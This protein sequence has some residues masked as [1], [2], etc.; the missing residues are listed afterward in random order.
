MTNEQ[1]RFLIVDQGIVGGVINF[2]VNGA[3]AWYLF[4]AMAQVPM[5]GGSQ[6]I[7][8]DVVGTF[9]LLPLIVCL[10]VTPLVRRQVRSGKLAALNWDRAT[11]WLYR[12]MPAS[13]FMRGLVLGVA[14]TIV[15]GLPLFGLM[16]AF[17]ITSMAYWDFVITKG[18]YAGVLA[19]IISPVIAFAALGDQLEVAP[20]SA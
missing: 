19:A 16:A 10:I 8:G 4:R 20:A 3:I 18:V 6:N 5:T 7:L 14:C 13:S 9:F 12:H 2:V 11:H 17:G 1:R 15:L